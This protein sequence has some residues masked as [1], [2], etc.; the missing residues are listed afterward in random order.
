MKRLRKKGQIGLL[1]LVVMSV[2]IAIAL[3]LAAR[4]L[5]DT[6]LSRQESESSRAFRVAENGIEKALNAL[7]KNEIPS[8]NIT[9]SVGV[10]EGSARVVSSLSFSLFVREGDQAG[11]DLST[12]DAN[13]DL[14]IKWT[15]LEDQSENIATCEE[16]SG[17]APAAIEVMALN[18]IINTVDFAY[19]NPYGCEPTIEFLDSLS[20]ES[21]GYLSVVNYNV[22]NGTTLLKIRPIYADTTI[23]VEGTG[24]GTQL[25][26]IESVASGGDAKKEIEVK[27]SL[28]MPAS[29]FDFALFSGSGILK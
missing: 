22:P 18:G 2:I 5:S 8:E 11:L 13:N 17:G 19:Y 7:R 1:L 28:D 12:Y 26:L 10:Y 9:Q 14:Q 27:R 6:A 4:T 21:D 3:N 16:G 20:G 29:V 15:R 25:Y 24:L 23:T